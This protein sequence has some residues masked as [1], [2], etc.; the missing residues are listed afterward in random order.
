MR[1]KAEMMHERQ[2]TNAA[3]TRGWSRGRASGQGG[4]GREE[5]VGA[6]E[7]GG[8]PRGPQTMLC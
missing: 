6:S 3:Q 7:D 5:V 4:S 8:L 2:R 1:E